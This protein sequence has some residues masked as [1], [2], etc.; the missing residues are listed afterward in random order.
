MGAWKKA[1]ASPFQSEQIGFVLTDSEKE[2]KFQQQRRDKFPGIRNFKGFRVYSLDSPA[3]CMLAYDK[4]EFCGP[5]KNTQ[6]V[7]DDYGN[8]RTLTVR[9]AARLH[10]FTERCI[11]NLTA[12]NEAKAYSMVGNSV[13]V[14]TMGAMLGAVVA[15][16]E[17][18]SSPLEANSAE[19]EED[20][21]QV[22]KELQR[23]RLPTT[24]ELVLAQKADKEVSSFR[25]QLT[26]LQRPG[27][28]VELRRLG[29]D[30]ARIMSLYQYSINEEGVLLHAP[31]RPHYYNKDGL[32]CDEEYNVLPATVVREQQV[33]DMVVVPKVLQ[34]T[35][36]YLHHYSAHAAH[37][38]WHDM[39]SRVQEAG[40]TWRGIKTTCMQM[41]RRCKICF[42]ASRDRSRQAGL[43]TSRR[44]RRPFEAVS[45]DF[46]ELGTGSVNGKKSLLTLLC[47]HTGFCELYPMDKDRA[48]AEE[49]ANALVKWSLRWG[50]SDTVWGG[51]DAQMAS[52][53]VRRVC[54]RLGI[55]SMTATAYN[56]NAISKQER[57][58][59]LINGVLKRLHQ[60]RP[61]TWNEHLQLVESRLRN[62][63]HLRA[64]YTPWQMVFGRKP[65]VPSNVYQDQQYIYE[66]A[67]A[68]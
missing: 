56:S 67:P 65:R 47:E 64:G 54:K 22:A 49:V 50:V 31:T 29:I 34:Q 1:D 10:N 20:A 8:I 9:E 7:L 12:L 55:T 16:L 13:P 58:H 62:T 17:H 32:S 30:Q 2:Q 26:M 41:C 61:E 21:Q 3:P 40:Y 6:F 25:E 27:G 68:G 15:A 44:F 39:V 46:Q 45:W 28:A 33:D 35:I 18:P 60:G 36:C 4:E 43:F 14:A 51:E 37:P 38:Q 42:R 11:D 59:H 53:V 24:E 19:A 23:L 48:T 57:K 5:G 66:E 52:E 63:L